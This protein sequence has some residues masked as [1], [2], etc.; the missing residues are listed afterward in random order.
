MANWTTLT[1]YLIGIYVGIAWETSK[2]IYRR[3]T[4]NKE[5]HK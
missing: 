1:W 4:V 3:I 5:N 2:F